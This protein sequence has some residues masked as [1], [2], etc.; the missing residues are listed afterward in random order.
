MFDT[1]R[2]NTRLKK[3]CIHL[4]IKIVNVHVDYVTGNVYKWIN[5]EI[6]YQISDISKH[7]KSN[8]ATYITLII[9][10][11]IVYCVSVTYCS[12]VVDKILERAVAYFDFFFK[13]I[14]V[15]VTK[16]HLAWTIFTFTKS[17]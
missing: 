10:C 15:Y 13:S 3:M 14:E 16:H 4:L 8:M 12:D 7:E 6:Y 1:A 5:T 2:L 9:L 11:V 17:L